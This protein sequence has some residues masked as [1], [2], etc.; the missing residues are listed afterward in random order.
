MFSPTSFV[1]NHKT[2]CSPKL[3]FLLRCSLTSTVQ[4]LDTRTLP[5]DF[6]ETSWLQ[7]TV[8]YE[9]T[10]THQRLT[11]FFKIRLVWIIS[12]FSWCLH[13]LESSVSSM[14]MALCGWGIV[15]P[16]SRGWKMP[17][18][19]IQ[20]TL[21]TTHHCQASTLC[22]SRRT[23]AKLP[24]RLCR[25]VCWTSSPGPL[26]I[27]IQSAPR[28]SSHRWRPWVELAGSL[29]WRRLFVEVWNLSV[30]SLTRL[31]GEGLRQLRVKLGF[32]FHSRTTTTQRIVLQD[33]K[34][35]FHIIL[36]IWIGHL[37][38]GKGALKNS[39]CDTLKTHFCFDG[40]PLAQ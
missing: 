2:L 13:C 33:V 3:V 35:G 36:K 7:R 26:K 4:T 17:A 15:T 24:R 32:R 27:S 9:D 22:Q 16:P 20:R 19:E 29:T 21:W 14:G 18:V 1:I 40:L 37:G 5:A 11:I 10:Q 30:R 23:E 25:A 12:Q 31:R 38:V 28:T 8:T 6:S 34:G 39:F